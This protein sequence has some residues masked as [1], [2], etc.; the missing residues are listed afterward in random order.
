[1]LQ[2]KFALAGLKPCATGSGEQM[3]GTRLSIIKRLS[4]VA[5]VIQVATQPV[6]PAKFRDLSVVLTNRGTR[7][8]IQNRLI[9]LIAL[10]GEATAVFR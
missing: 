5:R 6:I 9:T 10:R 2:R 3:D 7:A 8:G 4:M 1:M